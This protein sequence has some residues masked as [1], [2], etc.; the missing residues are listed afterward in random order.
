LRDIGDNDDWNG[1]AFEGWE[2]RHGW[3]QLVWEWDGRRHVIRRTSG[4][5]ERAS[6]AFGITGEAAEV[7]KQ[8]ATTAVRIGC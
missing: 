2:S 3:I 8:L 6:A 7:C 4:L 5:K 1:L